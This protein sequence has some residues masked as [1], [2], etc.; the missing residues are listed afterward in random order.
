MRIADLPHPS[1]RGCGHATASL[2]AKAG[3]ISV[4]SEKGSPTCFLTGSVYPIHV[5][6][7]NA[8][9]NWTGC[10]RKATAVD[11]GPFGNPA[12]QPSIESPGR[13]Q[14]PWYSQ[15]ALGFEVVRT[16]TISG[17][18]RAPTPAL[19]AELQEIRRRVTDGQA[20]QHP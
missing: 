5:G 1:P 9:S 7:W 2:R 17:A 3:G 19:A 18:G 20:P 8:V 15:G 16:A 13:P 10:S 6:N 4:S 12:I 11:G 14:R